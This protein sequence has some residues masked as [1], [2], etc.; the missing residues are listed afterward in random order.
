M[1][2]TPGGLSIDERC[3]PGVICPLVLGPHGSDFSDVI[4]GL[5]SMAE[6]DRGVLVTLGDGKVVRICAFTMAYTGDMPQQ[7]ENSGFKSSRAHSFCRICLIGA[8]HPHGVLD[9]DVVRHGR[10]HYQTMAMQRMMKELPTQARRDQYGAKWGI[11]NPDPALRRIS[12]ALDLITTRP[13]DG[14]HTEYNGLTN[15]LHF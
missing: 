1:Y 11:A 9:F 12:S 8:K 7:A 5:E 2:V 4:A 6:L 10:F 15:L 3:R 14:A 13:L